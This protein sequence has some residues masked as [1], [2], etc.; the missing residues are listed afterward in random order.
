M[1]PL[2]GAALAALLVLSAAPA[3]AFEPE[4]YGTPQPPADSDTAHSDTAHTEEIEPREDEAESSTPQ[5]D[6][7]SA[8]AP[9]S[10][11]PRGPDPDD[12][13]TPAPDPAADPAENAI[14][15]VPATI[16][17]SGRLLL[18]PN[19]PRVGEPGDAVAQSDDLIAGVLLAISDGAFLPVDTSA[20]DAALAPG[21]EFVGVATLPAS[22]AA[23]VASELAEEGSLSE[24]DLMETVTEAVLET[25]EKLPISG[26]V[27]LPTEATRETPV[28]AAPAPRAHTAD[29]AYIGGNRTFGE[30]TLK[31][32]VSQTGTYWNTQSDGAVTQLKVQKYVT[33]AL[34]PTQDACDTTSRWNQALELLKTGGNTYTNGHH[35]IVFVDSP[36]GCGGLAGLADIGTDMN[37]GGLIW[38]DIRAGAHSSEAATQPTLNK[39]LNTLAHEFGHNLSLG[40]SQSRVCTGLATDAPTRWADDEQNIGLL[41]V[42]KPSGTTCRDA[43]YGNTWDLMG[44]GYGGSKPTSVGVAQRAAL[45]V[46]PAGSVR[47][48]QAKNGRVQNFALNALGSNAGLRGLKID[49]PLGESFYLEYRDSVGQDSAGLANASS[50]PSYDGVTTVTAGV[51]LSKSY[52]SGQVIW[53]DGVW[54][55]Y[56]VKRATAVTNYRTS[57]TLPSRKHLTMVKNGV[58]TPVSSVARVKVADISGGTAKVSVEFT[59]FIDVTYD[60]KFGTEIN[61]MGDSGLSTGNKAGSGL[62]TYLPGDNVTREAMAAFLY[63]MK[64][65]ANYKAP[66]KSPFVDMKPGDKF[67]KEITWMH[68]ANISTG[69]KT[70]RG[71]VYEPKAGVTREAMAAF[72]YRMDDTSKPAAPQVSPFQDMTPT[73]KFYREIAWM[74]TA[75]VSTGTKQPVGKPKYLPKDTVTREAMAAFIYRVNH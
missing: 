48:V 18:L 45:G 59:P 22:A 39:S 13:E 1:K 50:R 33:Q 64:A 38:V 55:P 8:D 14:T 4:Q 16:E 11:D 31:S 68:S 32:L 74:Y 19:E 40:H 30:A 56:A 20:L 69:T 36:N 52:P 37:F 28:G 47:T 57:G 43:E 21:A 46:N 10:A 71:T 15:S 34:L 25:Q 3:Q 51:V 42:L 26:S 9:A 41:R 12:D 75:G 70:P 66:T 60:H 49:N 58:S 29:V 17:V 6:E 53:S 5:P 35:L 61:W 7:T 72:L 44:V 24:A 63:R 73:S 23:A 67:Y 65:P 2:I 62:F 54:R 27:V